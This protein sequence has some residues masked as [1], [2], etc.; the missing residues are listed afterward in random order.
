MRRLARPL[1]YVGIVVIVFGLAK[2]HAG[3]SP[4]RLRLHGLVA[5][6]AGRSP[7][8]AC[9][10]SPPTAIGL[11]DLPRTLGSRPPRPSPRRSPPPLGISVL[12]LVTG[13]ALLPRFVVFGSACSSSRGRCSASRSPADGRITGRQRDRVVLVA[14]PREAVALRDELAAEPER[15]AALLNHLTPAEAAAQGRRSR[16]LVELV[17]EHRR[18]PRRPRP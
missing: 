7:T 13:D 5:V 8:A 14:E 16:P 6:R 18:Q 10:S 4:S 17:I 12:Q 3:T 1:L 2:Y 9:W 15:P 11:P